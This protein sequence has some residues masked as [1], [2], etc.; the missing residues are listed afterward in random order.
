MNLP[1]STDLLVNP[2]GSGVGDPA[3]VRQGGRRKFE[4]VVNIVRTT[5][6][7][8]FDLA[9]ATAHDKSQGPQRRYDPPRVKNLLP[10]HTDADSTP[11][12]IWEG[13]VLDVDRRAG[14]MQVLLEAKIGQMP[15]HTGEVEMEWVSEQD[16]DLVRPG[17]VFY[18]TLFKR[19]RRGSIE[20]SQELRFRRRPS[21]STAQLK[22]IEDD[23]ALLLSKMRPLPTSA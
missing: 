23:A 3:F 12:Q 8:D 11:I 21:W 17:A 18:L 19:T 5:R 10:I 2:S 1:V 4:P 15:R 6:S 20:N 22:Q 9:G 7:G 16:Q 14:V 13:T